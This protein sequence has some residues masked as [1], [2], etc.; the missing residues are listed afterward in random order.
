MTEFASLCRLACMTIVSMPMTGA[1]SGRH[2]PRVKQLQHKILFVFQ[3][4]NDGHSNA[5]PGHDNM[6]RASSLRDPKKGGKALTM[7]H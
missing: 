3:E 6:A 7:A 2:P 5:Q 1:E 4:T